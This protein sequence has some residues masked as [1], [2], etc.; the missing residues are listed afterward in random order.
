MPDVSVGARAKAAFRI[1]SFDEST[2][3]HS[4]LN[5]WTYPRSTSD[6]DSDAE[7]CGS[8]DLI[9][10]LSESIGQASAFEAD[11]TL[12]GE[13]TPNDLIL[14]GI[15][16]AGNLIVSGQFLGI[17]K[18]IALA[19]GHERQSSPAAYDSILSDF[20]DEQ[21]PSEPLGTSQ[22]YSLNEIFDADCTGEYVK[23]TDDDTVGRFNIARRIT[24]TNTGAGAGLNY[25]DYT[26]AISVNINGT[27]AF[28][29]GRLWRHIYEGSKA[30]CGEDK[31]WGSE[32]F[33]HVRVG[34]LA[35]YKVVGGTNGIW[36]YRTVA[37][38][39]MRFSL[40]PSGVRFEFSLIPFDIDRDSS[41]NTDESTWTYNHSSAV[42]A[43]QEKMKW[44]NASLE[45]TDYVEEGGSPAGG[46]LTIPVS[47]FELNVRN[48]LSASSRDL[49]SGLYRVEPAR[50]GMREVTGSF[51]FPRY[52]ADAEGWLDEFDAETKL[53][54]TLT[55]DGEET[56]GGD[57]GLKNKFQIW[58]RTLKITSMRAEI[59]GQGVTEVTVEFKCYMPTNGQ[60]GS[61]SVDPA[62][63]EARTE[64]AI[65]L[66]NGD[67]FNAFYDTR[68]E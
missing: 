7:V 59:I 49:K 10:L 16:P 50:Q 65:V 36:E 43:V 31:T 13:V 52:D 6:A 38:D 28:H 55:I 37:C 45:L 11:A 18:L 32:A 8:F 24:A 2:P 33:T 12:D 22:V 14:T 25:I 54:A 5:T 44:A 64:L 3:A 20:T 15:L 35:I 68:A 63:E 48:N 30:M 4:K 26:P 9:P 53:M 56:I 1:C 46:D 40:E 42:G 29:V 58:L 34:T 19:L 17:G 57:I 23:F 51:S 47:R 60:Y 61:P 21:N 39:A 41:V 27:Q 67:P 62:G 66:H